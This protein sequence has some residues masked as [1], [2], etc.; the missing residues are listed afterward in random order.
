M[1]TEETNDAINEFTN[2]GPIES[3]SEAD[4]VPTPQAGWS[5]RTFFKA[6]AIGAA[7]ATFVGRDGAGHLRLGAASASAAN[8]VCRAGDIEVSG[9]EAINEPCTC[10]GSF[11]PQF[12][13][14]VSNQNNANRTCITLILGANSS[15]N[16]SFLAGARLL[17]F[18]ESGPNAGKSFLSGF[19]SNVPMVGTPVDANG[20]PISIPCNFGQCCFTES[21]VAFRTA[22]NQSDTTCAAPLNIGDFAPAQCRKST[23]CLTGFGVQV[24]CSDANCS[25]GTALSTGSTAQDCASA[26]TCTV[27]CGGALYL[28][29]TAI[30]GSDPSCT[31]LTVSLS[32]P[33]ITGS[34]APTSSVTTIEN[35]APVTTACFTVPAAQVQTG[36]YTVTATDC[37]GCTR[38]A[39]INV[40]A[41]SITASL[42]VSGNTGCTAGV[43]TFTASTNGCSGTPTFEFSVDGTVVQAASTSNTFTYNPSL[44][45]GGGLNT[46]CHT[47]SVLANCAGCTATA[48]QTV[49]QCVS[50]T[51]GC[52]PPA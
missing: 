2:N 7:A 4:A 36:C 42:G 17:L 32:G 22:Q 27:A 1:S 9:G 8:L 6:A 46:G 25:T 51:L 47:V 34:L 18:A 31:T 15:S 45:A 3:A 28:K 40:A 14:F 44:V 39:K 12:R 19:Q 13:F 20:N 52:T 43:L 37:K 41:G 48:S 30:G 16:C 10:T 33:G 21:A 50:T 26:S 5:R 24:A 49:S 38:S 29:A 23:I 11:V 35:G